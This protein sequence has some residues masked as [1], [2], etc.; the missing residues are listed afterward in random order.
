[1]TLLKVKELAKTIGLTLIKPPRA[2]RSGKMLIR[3][4]LRDEH[5]VLYFQNLGD[6][7]LYLR[8]RKSSN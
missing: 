7:E 5:G 3:Y 4:L 2:L 6:V 8:K 1:M